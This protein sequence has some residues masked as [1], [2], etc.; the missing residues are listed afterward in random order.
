MLRESDKSLYNSL[1]GTGAKFGDTINEVSGGFNT[2]ELFDRIDQSIYLILSTRIGE[3][4]FLPDFGCNL[5]LLLFENDSSLFRD[6]A[7]YYV[8]DALKKWEPRINVLA[9]HVSDIKSNIVHITITYSLIRSNTVHNYVYP[10]SRGL[11]A[12]GGEIY[13]E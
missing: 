12:L 1:I 11:H 8:R 10:F 6:L 3:R 4:F 13:A 5:Y 2:S 9:I 7:D